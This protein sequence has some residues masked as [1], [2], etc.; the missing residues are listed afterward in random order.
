MGGLFDT[1]VTA[2]T[3]L[4]PGVRKRRMLFGKIRERIDAQDVPAGSFRCDH[5]GR[6]QSRHAATGLATATDGS[7]VAVWCMTC[8]EETTESVT[9]GRTLLGVE[10]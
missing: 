1:V 5:C 10:Q 2:V 9:R 4:H 8:V 6:V 3:G 7:D